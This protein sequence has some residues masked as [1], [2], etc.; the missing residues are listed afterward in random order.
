MGIDTKIT[1][2]DMSN[3]VNSETVESLREKHNAIEMDLKKKIVALVKSREQ[4]KEQNEA[5]SSEISKY[6]SRFKEINGLVQKLKEERDLYKTKAEDVANSPPVSAANEQV[7]KAKEDYDEASKEIGKILL[8][9][10]AMANQIV[11]D[12]KSKV[13]GIYAESLQSY[14]SYAKTIEATKSELESINLTVENIIRSFQ[15]QI[16]NI[17][18]KLDVAKK[19]LEKISPSPFDLY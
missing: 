7:L 1:P 19:N 5:Y 3:D 14:A 10:K 2:F 18:D 4:L 15:L 17:A 16:T 11:E 9:A 13:K 12:A 6:V 8:D